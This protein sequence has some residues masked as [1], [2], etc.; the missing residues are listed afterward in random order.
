MEQNPWIYFGVGLLSTI[1]VLL[2]CLI[3]VLDTSTSTSQSLED[4]V[5][6]L[7]DKMIERVKPVIQVNRATIYNTEGEIVLEVNDNGKTTR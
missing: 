2:L 6:W 4:R 3:L 7:E 1:C 5:A